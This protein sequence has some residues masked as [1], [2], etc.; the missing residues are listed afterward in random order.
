MTTRRVRKLPAIPR[1][2]F[3][4]TVIGGSTLETLDARTYIAPDEAAAVRTAR[5]QGMRGEL[6]CLAFVAP[7]GYVLVPAVAQ[8]ALSRSLQSIPQEEIT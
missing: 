5:E 2:G 6:Y 1:S 4:W 7:A 8:A 3:F